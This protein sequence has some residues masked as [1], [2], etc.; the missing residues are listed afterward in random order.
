MKEPKY[1][2]IRL[3]LI[4][5]LIIT[6]GVFLRLW[7]FTELF[8]FAVDEEKGAYIIKGIA[9]AT[10][11]PAAGHPTSIGFRLGPI[12][13]Y[14][15][16]PLFKFFTPNPLTI[17]YF[18]IFI[19]FFTMI[20]LFNIAR[21][22]NLLTGI[23]SVILYGF[24][25]LNIIYDRRGWQLSFES[26]LILVIIFSM[27]K[28]R[29][30]KQFFIYPLT[31]SL[32]ILTQFEVGL[33]TL[34]PKIILTFIIFKIKISYKQIIISLLLIFLANLPLLV[35][36]LRHQF[37][38]T[39]YLI[40]YFKHDQ[41]VRIAPNKPLTH[42]RSTYLAHNIIP[43]TLTRVLFPS[44]PDDLSVQYANCPQYLSLKQ[45]QVKKIYIVLT[46]A[47]ITTAIIIW[48]KSKN[49]SPVHFLLSISFIYFLLHFS[50]ISLYTYLFQGEMAE[51]YLI[52][53]FVFLFITIGT[54]LSYL[55]KRKLKWL[56][57]TILVIFI[58]ENTIKLIK[59][60]NSYSLR[61]KL[62]AVKYS[63]N[64]VGNKNFILESFQTCWYS[65]GYRYLYTLFG[66]EP[67]TSYMDQYLSE[68]Y[69]PDDATKPEY[70]VTIL[71]PELIGENPPGYETYREKIAREADFMNKFG[72]IEVYIKQI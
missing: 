48:K 19:S 49:K 17:G 1:R 58:L 67:L 55:Y 16:F 20:L 2:R 31:L 45:S 6:L 33:F 57:I 32:I 28:L 5:S 8:Y 64:I 9:D 50:A 15:T 21:K 37:L 41:S 47:L 34:I 11:F 56:I 27:L 53:T 39:K 54:S 43:Y 38:N 10:H 29:E 70:Q 44:G 22:I 60:N 59:S 46:I 63:L 23:F 13:Y 61:N 68:Y 42:Q 66:K 26:P 69:Q 18:S 51:Y 3:Y 72:A 36:D 24:S 14:L 25:Y 35:F 12:F 65:G 30:G 71:T 40:N 62:Q 4:I 52:P 7:K